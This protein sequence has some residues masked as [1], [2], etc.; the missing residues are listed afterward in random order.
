M[1]VP[2]VKI[3]QILFPGNK[4]RLLA[5]E[6]ALELDEDGG[7]VRLTELELL[8]FMHHGRGRSIGVFRRE[9]GEFVEIPA[10]AF[11]P[12]PAR[13]ITKLQGAPALAPAE[14]SKKRG[15]RKKAVDSQLA[16]VEQ[17]KKRGRLV[18]PPPQE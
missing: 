13:G 4:Y 17:K 6:A 8:E 2:M 12:R 11:D 5:P 10:H 16:K 1:S 18:N 15:A 3:G 14:I 7:T 9:N